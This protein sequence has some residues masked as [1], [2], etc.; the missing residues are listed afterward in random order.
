MADADIERD[1]KI[2]RLLDEM[3][4]PGPANHAADTLRESNPGLAE[5]VLRLAET[6]QLL[7]L[8][9]GDWKGG[10][11]DDTISS[12]ALDPRRNTAAEPLPLQFGGTPLPDGIGRYRI[13]RCL[14]QGGMGTVFEA[15]DPQLQRRVAIKVP[16][17]LGS[18]ESQQQ[19]QRRFLREARSAAAVEHPNVCSIHDVGEHDGRPFVVMVF[20]EGE[21]LADR[22]KRRPSQDCREAAALLV[23]VAAGLA[24]VHAHG[25]T[26]RDLKPANILIRAKDGEPILTDFGLAQIA[27]EDD[28]LT[29]EGAILG[30]PAYMAPEQADPS[31]GPVTL[32]SDLY[33]L[34]VILFEM[35]TGRRPFEGSAVYW[36]P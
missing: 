20:V 35:V 17:F 30:T 5:E 26:H 27:R 3:R 33:S 11:H 1:E 9:A 21:T 29:A 14:G 32:Q 2:S 31:L 19:S 6:E 16:H 24:A 12:A 13:V 18:A 10:C 8:A 28:N 22:L 15:D 25:I 36:L 4:L 23:K 7:H 34:G